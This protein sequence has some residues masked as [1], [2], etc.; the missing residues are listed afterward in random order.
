MYIEDAD[1]SA[2]T[3]ASTDTDLKVTVDGEEYSAEANYDIDGDGINESI[4]METADGHAVYSD[5]DGD[6]DADLLVQL[7]ESGDVTSAAGYDEATGEWTYTDPQDIAGGPGSDSIGDN[8]D[9]ADYG[10]PGSDADLDSGGTP[11]IIETP[12]GTM[13]TG[14]ATEDI[15]GDGVPDTAVVAADNGSILIVSDVNGDG[16]ADMVAEFR[17]DDSVVVSEHAGDGEWIVTESGRLDDEGNF[18]PDAGYGSDTSNDLSGGPISSAAA[19]DDA[20]WADE[21]WGDEATASPVSYDISAA[22]PA[23]ASAGS[24]DAQAQWG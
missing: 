20:A 24:S 22:F 8:Y 7:D 5:I 19:S 4:V 10:T 15:D 12:S 11:L 14:P 23:T 9:D 3:T 1:G 13:E 6:G 16:E 18:V 17:T 2:D 21:D